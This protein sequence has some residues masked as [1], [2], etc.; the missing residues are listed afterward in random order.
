M[1]AV[2][3]VRLVESKE[4]LVSS[5]IWSQIVDELK[6]ELIKRGDVPPA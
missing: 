4:E 2:E 5:K 6:K 3:I 1:L